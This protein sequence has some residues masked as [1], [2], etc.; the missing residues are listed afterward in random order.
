MLPEN[1]II[2][3]VLLT[4]NQYGNLNNL[5]TAIIEDEYNPQNP[6]F[7]RSLIWKATFITDSL[8]IQLWPGQ[9]SNS[10]RV[11][12][13]LI[14][15]DDML[16]PWYKLESD[17][18][19]YQPKQMSRNTS[20]RRKKKTTPNSFKQK[21][22]LTSVESSSDP[23]NS[24]GSEQEQYMDDDDLDLLKTI[25]LDID[26]LFPGDE[27]FLS[28][29]SSLLYKRQLIEILY[30]W[31]KCNPK[32]GY[33]QGFHEILGLI[34]I[35]LRKDSLDIP[36]TNTF[37]QDDLK[38][39]T[40]FDNKFICHDLFT[41]FNNFMVKSGII[42]NFYENEHIL[43]EFIE[44][45]N[46]Y[47]MKVDQLIH[48]SLIS[49]L[50]LESQLWCIRY[51][52]L[53]LLREIGHD[54]SVISYLWDKLIV[55]DN[56]KIP[57]LI[58]FIIIVM[59]INL[60]SNLIICDFSE[61]LSMLLHYPITLSAQDQASAAFIL[62]LFSDSYKLLKVKDNDLKLYEYGKKI[63]AKCNPDL[64]FSLSY[65]GESR[66]N[67]ASPMSSANNTSTDVTKPGQPSSTQSSSDT[68]SNSMAEKMA[69]EKYRL[70]MRLKKKAQ[71]LMRQ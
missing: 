2:S 19:F 43:L 62:N 49:K 35:N 3:K 4:I 29:D 64:K 57:Q 9:L 63:N 39:L 40:L 42:A 16:I 28:G 51:L 52:R 22:V 10:R 18:T 12:H 38:I 23:L 44:L 67:T 36:N 5:K 56:N 41:I 37:A 21:S 33:K 24:S 68:N 59:L 45:F 1:T 11:Y 70:E 54:L 61:S 34:Y 48:Y 71:L 50:K 13:E 65:S 6:K 60:K 25:I 8:N 58:I 55:V 69:F 27:E 31:S 66:S 46:N 32:V 7:L 26:R 47:L 53:I 20:L 17:S 15:G 30:V 14:K